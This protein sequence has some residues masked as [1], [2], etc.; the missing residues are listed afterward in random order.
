[1]DRKVIKRGICAYPDYL[2]LSGRIDVPALLDDLG[3]D[4]GFQLKEHQFMCHCPNLTGN[5]LN[6]DQNPSFGFNDE[7]LAFNCFS[8]GGG[9]VIEMVQMMKPGMTEDEALAYLETFSDLTP[10]SPDDILDKL[11]KMMN[12]PEEKPKIMPEFPDN[13]LFGFRKI[14]PYLLDRGISEEVIKEM[15]VG[16]DDVHC[17]IT[18]PH[19]FMGKLVGW[20]T[21]HLVQDA[22]GKYMCEHQ[23]CNFDKNGKPIKVPKYKN[24]PNFPKI[25]TLYGYDQ[26]KR[27]M[28]ERVTEDVYVVESP[29]SCLYMKSL[30]YWNTVATFGSFNIEQGMLLLPF[31]RVVF[32]PDNDGAGLLNVTKAIQSIARYNRLDVVPVVNKPKGDANDLRPEEVVAHLDATYNSSLFSLLA[33]DHLPTLEDILTHHHSV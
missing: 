24:T 29:M 5:H 33:K 8:C 18:I 11:Q 10:G 15:Q 21:R 13:A 23:S 31:N 6:G 14:H 30:G 12:P 19:W 20:Q 7:K 2:Y 32:W 27:S 26:L 4:L 16:F 3:I 1:M 25:N 9:N 22:E 17:G 28:Q